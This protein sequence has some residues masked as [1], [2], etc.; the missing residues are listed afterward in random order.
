MSERLGVCDNH[1]DQVPV[2]SSGRL[3][4]RTTSCVCWQEYTPADQVASG[5]RLLPFVL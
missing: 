2:G 4:P 3:H 1:L 5:G